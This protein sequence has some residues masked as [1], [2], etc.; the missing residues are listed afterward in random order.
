[1]K[2]KSLWT[3]HTLEQNPVIY[4]GQSNLFNLEGYK[5]QSYTLVFW[6]PWFIFHILT[7]SVISKSEKVD[8]HSED[9]DA[10]WQSTS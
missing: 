2:H 8:G 5:S 9:D 7:L 3:K 10:E 4:H 6:H 1:M